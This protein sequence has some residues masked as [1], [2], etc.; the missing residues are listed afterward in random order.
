MYILRY[1]KQAYSTSEADAL[2]DG[3]HG[4]SRRGSFEMDSTR[5]DG[6][7][8]AQALSPRADQFAG[9]EAAAESEPE[10][11]TM[12]AGSLRR[13]VAAAVPL[14]GQVRALPHLH[15]LVHLMPF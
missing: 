1:G 4:S 8:S 12:P 13:D 7:R 15:W 14:R 5:R 9:L 11:L 10:G 2:A 3:R 6:R